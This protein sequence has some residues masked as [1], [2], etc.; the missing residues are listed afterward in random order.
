M[1]RTAY[2][3]ASLL[4]AGAA[5]LLTLR[6]QHTVAVVVASHDLRSGRQVQASDVQVVRMHDEGLP[7]GTLHDTD[8]VVGRYLVWPAAAGEPL[9]SRMVRTQ[10]SGASVL[11]GLA[12][13]DGYRAVAVPVQPAGAVGGMLVPGDRVDVWATPIAGRGSAPT[14]PSSGGSS[15]PPADAVLLGR[16]VLVLELRSDQGQPLDQAAQQTV[17]GLNFGVGKL[18]SVVLAVPAEDVDHYAAAAAEDTIYL[19]LGVG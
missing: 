17:R 5:A 2:L 8:E 12:V 14:G 11:A 3:V 7:T 6:A 10:R 9:L 4:L 19:A 15:L 1:R 18:G 13:P 16:D